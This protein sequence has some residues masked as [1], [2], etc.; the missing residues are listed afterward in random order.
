MIG[1]Y[2]ITNSKGAIYIGQAV[3]IERRKKDYSRAG[4]KSQRKIYNSIKKYGWKDH[5]FEVLIENI[6]DG[7]FK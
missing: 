1:I 5:T 3:N 2:K 6:K 4:C 7:Q